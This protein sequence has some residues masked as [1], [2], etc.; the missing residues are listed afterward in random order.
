MPDVE[1][2][3]TLFRKYGYHFT[4]LVAIAV[5]MVAG[6]SA[7]RAVFWATVLAVGLSFLRRE[8]ALT[9]RRLVGGARERA[10]PASSASAPRPPPRASSSASS[11]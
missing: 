6:M 4:S 3:A 11:R 10:R 9:P 2:P 5:F 8:T 1:P 7:F